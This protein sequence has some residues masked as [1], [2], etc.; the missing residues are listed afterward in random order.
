MTTQSQ[1]NICR[2]YLA[3]PQGLGNRYSDSAVELTLKLSELPGKV[4]RTLATHHVGLVQKFKYDH[5]NVLWSRNERVTIRAKFMAC[6]IELERR[7]EF[8]GD[9]RE[10]YTHS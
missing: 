9:L 6:V 1:Q 5:D 10:S 2:D 3:K 4:I 8:C 7:G